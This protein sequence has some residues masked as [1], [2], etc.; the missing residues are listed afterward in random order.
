[1]QMMKLK[2][3]ILLNF[4]HSILNV[5]NEVMM[6]VEFEQQHNGVLISNVRNDQEPSKVTIHMLTDTPIIEINTGFNRPIEDPNFDNTNVENGLILSNELCQLY[7]AIL[8]SISAEAEAID[9]SNINETALIAEVSENP[10]NMPPSTPNTTQLYGSIDTIQVSAFSNPAAQQIV[11]SLNEN[12]TTSMENATYNSS[13]LIPNINGIESFR[14][15]VIG[16]MEEN[17]IQFQMKGQDT[18]QEKM[19]N[20]MI[21]TIDMTTY[22]SEVNLNDDDI[23]NG[24]DFSV[25]PQRGISHEEV[26]ISSNF[27]EIETVDAA[28]TVKTAW[29]SESN[30][31]I[32]GKIFGRSQMFCAELKEKCLFFLQK[33]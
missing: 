8:A 12:I 5:C 24:M 4:L 28:K 17:R 10:L 29:K 15:D 20:Q 33:L 21:D 23:D 14:T 9:P 26:I 27:I 3:I 13:L 1:M 18:N 7:E 25:A 11:S 22:E 30:K 31:S 19:I 6:E 2:Q 32:Q 16:S